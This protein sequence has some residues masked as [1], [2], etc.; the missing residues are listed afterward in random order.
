MVTTKRS[1]QGAA[2]TIA[3]AP[4]P[5]RFVVTIAYQ[6]PRQEGRA[7][8]PYVAI[9]IT[10]DN[11][12]LVRALTMLGRKLDY[13]SE[14]YIWWRRYGRARPQVVAAISRPTKPAGRYSVAWDGKDDM[15]A[16]VGQGRYIVHIEAAREDGLHSYQSMALT[17]GTDPAEAAAPAGDELGPSSAHY[18]RR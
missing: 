10:D 14:N 18:G 13:V 16:A 11:N 5:D 3:A 15:G 12:R 2:E 1:G 7:H 8:S 9:W 17:L 4:W 6:L